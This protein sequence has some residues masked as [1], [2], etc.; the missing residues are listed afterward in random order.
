MLDTWP[1]ASGGDGWMT[2]GDDDDATR[3]LEL[4]LLPASQLGVKLSCGGLMKTRRQV[5]A[6]GSL[7]VQILLLP[8]FP[9]GCARCM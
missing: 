9:A 1:S 5:S 8:L 3:S 2:N 4:S 6:G 7:T